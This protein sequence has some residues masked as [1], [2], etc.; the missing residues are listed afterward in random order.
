MILLTVLLI[1]FGVIVAIIRNNSTEPAPKK[2]YPKRSFQNVFD[3]LGIL[4]YYNNKFLLRSIDYAFGNE[5]FEYDEIQ[6]KPGFPIL[7]HSSEYQ[8]KI[9]DSYND[10]RQISEIIGLLK[11]TEGEEKITDFMINELYGQLS[12]FRNESETYE[13]N[14]NYC[15][16]YLQ[17]IGLITEE[18]FIVDGDPI[19][20]NRTL[21]N[22]SIIF[23]HSGTQSR[24]INH[25]FPKVDNEKEHKYNAVNYLEQILIK[26][27]RENKLYLELEKVNIFSSIKKIKSPEKITGDNEYHKLVNRISNG[28]NKTITN[29]IPDSGSKLNLLSISCETQIKEWQDIKDAVSAWI[30]NYQRLL[31]AYLKKD[32]L[33][34]FNVLC[35]FEDTN[36]LLSPETRSVVD[37]ISDLK[38][39]FLESIVSLEN[40]ISSEVLGL[41]DGL[42]SQLDEVKAS[43]NA[44]AISAAAAAVQS[45]RGLNKSNSHG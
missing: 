11:D 41:K 44:A 9:Q 2:E 30:D 33:T 4:D 39:E 24:L 7:S 45:T 6:P 3:D 42:E 28:L 5:I 16:S 43:A 40:S 32:N 31:D 36:Y 38:L 21:L 26:I 12:S 22:E 29:V 15:I 25:A 23:N 17:D 18:E 13:A 37:A 14:R 27:L 10:D 19:F 35:L 8:K 1:V 34:F 20:A